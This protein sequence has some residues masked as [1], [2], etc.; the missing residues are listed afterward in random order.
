MDGWNRIVSF[1]GPAHFQVICLVSGRVINMFMS[2][3]HFISVVFLITVLIGSWRYRDTHIETTA[4]KVS[5]IVRMG[6][7]RSL[8]HKDTADQK[9]IRRRQWLQITS[10]WDPWYYSNPYIVT[11][12]HFRCKVD[13]TIQQ[14][15][16]QYNYITHHPEVVVRGCKLWD[17]HLHIAQVCWNP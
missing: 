5:I 10:P 12:C 8:T 1:W 9:I 11:H 17:L 2:L 13:D 4:P 7:Q 15:Q 16:I 14:K 6:N 3:Y